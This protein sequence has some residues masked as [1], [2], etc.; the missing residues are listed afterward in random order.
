[1]ELDIRA[2]AFAGEANHLRALVDP[3]DVG[4]ARQELLRVQAGAASRI[5]HP[6]A[7]NVPEQIQD[8]GTVVQRVVGAAGRM[9]LVVLSER[10]VRGGSTDGSTMSI[11]QEA[12]SIRRLGSVYPSRSYSN[13]T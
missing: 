10:V 11:M 13:I 12:A 7:P 6:L 4:A 3:D 8:R 5:E 9:L 2:K 1:M